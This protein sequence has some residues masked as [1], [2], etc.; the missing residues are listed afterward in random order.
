MGK[1]GSFSKKLANSTISVTL[2]DDYEMCD[3]I[4]GIDYTI[5]DDQFLSMLNGRY[6]YDNN[7]EMKLL[8]ERKDKHLVGKTLRFRSPITC[9]S[10][11]GICKYCYGHM[12]DINQSMF[13]AGTLASL[14]ITEP[15]GQGILSSKHSQSTSSSE[16][17]FTEGYDDVFE[18]TSSVVSLRE[19]SSLDANMYI[20]LGEVSV[21][22]S[23]DSETYYIQ[24]FDLVDE[25]GNLVRHIEEASG[26]RLYLNEKLLQMYKN[27]LRSRSADPLFS[28][29]DLDDADSLFTIEVK[30]KELTEPLKVF[31]KILNSRDHGGASSLSELAQLFAEKLLQMNIRYE[32][33]HAEMILR[34]LIRKR[35]NNLEVPDFSAAGNPEDYQVLKLDD[36]L[37]HNPS[38][39]VGMSYGYLRRALMSPELYQKTA[40]GP[41]DS[42]AVSALSEYL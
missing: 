16:L 24:C 10:K 42:L 11:E 9:N 4:H 1:P 28:L 17:Q 6:Y 20:K 3:S 22:E 32:F 23:D 13:S 18:T 25:K 35:T 37:F 38:V 30:N 36:A 39:L 31:T 5:K 34:S 15:I 33:V 27:K 40:P 8:D 19:E 29:E 14:K 26:A 41:F 2:R 21:E 7:G 12:F